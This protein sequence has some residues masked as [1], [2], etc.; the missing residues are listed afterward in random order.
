MYYKISDGNIYYI[1]GIE[2]TRENDVL[3][4]NVLYSIHHFIELR[5]VYK[6]NNI[7]M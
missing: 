1:H 4:K 6:K 7:L 5:V 2:L 3:E